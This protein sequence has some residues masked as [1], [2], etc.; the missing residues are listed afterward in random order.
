ML[1]AVLAGRFVSQVRATMLIEV[2]RHTASDMRHWQELEAADLAHA[3]TL[4]RKEQQALDVICEFARKDCYAGV[5][6]GKDSTVLA[7]LIWRAAEEL[8]W[9]VP[10]VW[11]KVNP[12]CNPH[13]VLV[14][15]YF[16]GRWEINYHQIDVEC[17]RDLFGVHAT[18][19]LET[20]FSRAAERFGDRY[21]SGIRSE[22]S[23]G[24]SLRGI[25]HGPVTKRT[26]APLQYWRTRDVFAYLAKYSLP[27]HP[28]YGM[29]GGGRWDRDRIRVA[30]LGG[31]RGDGAGRV[32]WES[33][34]YSDWLAMFDNPH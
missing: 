4:E 23:G 7:H 5:S 3:E 27:V 21:L 24:R 26:C 29:L 18:G 28:A 12:I 20:G 14:E 22:E 30:S 1:P 19:T 9:P 13:C 2:D 10:C 33:E 16:L 8:R 6:W 15:K 25:I 32:E 31:R 11:V 34:Y 17:R